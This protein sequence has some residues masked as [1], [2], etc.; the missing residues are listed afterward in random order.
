MASDGTR[1]L[2]RWE[3]LAVAAAKEEDLD[4]LAKI[5]EELCAALEQRNQQHKASRNQ[6]EKF[7][8]S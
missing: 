7:E 3:D 4:K 8:A 5:I 1:Q 6:D 2:S